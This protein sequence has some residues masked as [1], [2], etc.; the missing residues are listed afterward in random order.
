MVMLTKKGYLVYLFDPRINE[1]KIEHKQIERIETLQKEAYKNDKKIGYAH[2]INIQNSYENTK[3][4]QFMTGSA[5]SYQLAIFDADFEI[6][7]DMLADSVCNKK[8]ELTDF[9][10]LLETISINSDYFPKT[11]GKLTPWEMMQLEKIFPETITNSQKLER[12]II[13]QASNKL[14]IKE[15]TS[16]ITSS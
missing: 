7:S 1:N 4:G 3:H 8:T 5:L 15:R 14:W 12:S 11:W 13:G 6:I 2:V 9:D 16:R 10:L